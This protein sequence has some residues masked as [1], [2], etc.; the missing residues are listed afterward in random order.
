MPQTI[1]LIG[2]GS[3]AIGFLLETLSLINSAQID[4]KQAKDLV[5][6]IFEESALLGAGA[7]YD[8]TK[9]GFQLITNIRNNSGTLPKSGADYLQWLEENRDF[10]GKVFDKIFA[11]RLAAKIAKAPEKEDLF[12]QSYAAIAKNFKEKYLNLDDSAKT[13]HP[14]ILYGIYRVA[15]FEKVVEELRARGVVINEY[16]KSKVAGFQQGADGKFQLKIESPD[17]AP[18]AETDFVLFAG[19]MVEKA[20][21][22]VH[23]NFLSSQFP[24]ENLR[25]QLEKLV[26][27]AKKTNKKEIK[28]GILG[29]SLSAIDA[30]RTIYYEKIF[31][32]Q[33]DFEIDGIKIKIDLISRDGRL[34]KVRAAYAPFD[35]KKDG[36]V[37]PEISMLKEVRELYKEND[38]IHLWQVLEICAQKMAIFYRHF[39]QENAA[40]VALDFATSIRDKKENYQEILEEFAKLEG[41][42][43]F[44]QLK[45]ELA[46]A[47]NGDVEKMLG[48]QVAYGLA[49]PT[50]PEILALL[51][52]DDKKIYQEYFAT[53]H[54][55]NDSPMPAP[56]AQNLL[57]LHEQGLVDIVKL[58][59]KEKELR[60]KDGQLFVVDEDGES[61]DYDFVIRANGYVKDLQHSE[62]EFHQKI[63]GG[64]NP[65]VLAPY[66]AG[67]GV[68]AAQEFGKNAAD[69]L[70]S[71]IFG[72]K[73]ERPQELDLKA[74]QPQQIIKHLGA[75]QIVAESLKGKAISQ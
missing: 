20:P 71:M 23:A 47:E 26:E 41:A 22:L 69:E 72:E 67:I 73:M 70:M 35:Y 1:S 30:V 24:E 16:G 46:R 12:C 75:M 59:H 11:Q 68:A 10:I 48:Y 62:S 15:L 36:G 74:Q 5:V 18:F 4:E 33:P 65:K 6:N 25:A 17:E 14:R 52:E 57:Q 8:L 51:N 38:K 19:G 27:E 43:G 53:L 63:G 28:L 42:Q 13:Y 61:H 66:Q 34:P 54:N 44:S 55:L 49:A 3:T 64:S 2:S 56:V 58:G 7:P 31:Q 29:S 60:S 32:G 39:G 50:H 21:Q 40:Q 45:A 37:L 9:T